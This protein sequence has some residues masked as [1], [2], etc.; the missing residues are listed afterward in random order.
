MIK[1]YGIASIPMSVFNK[2]GKDNKLI[3][4]CFAKDTDTLTK[5]SKLLCKI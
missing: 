5:A 4:F 3:R 2:D 1:E